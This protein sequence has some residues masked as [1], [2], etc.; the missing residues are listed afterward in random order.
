MVLVQKQAFPVHPSIRPSIHPSFC[1]PS[2]TSLSVH[3]CEQ[4]PQHPQQ[5]CPD[6]GLMQRGQEDASPLR[7]R[8]AAET[9][10][11]GVTHAA[12]QRS[13]KRVLTQRAAR[14]PSALTEAPA[15][16]LFVFETKNLVFLPASP[17]S[18]LVICSVTASVEPYS[19]VLLRARSPLQRHRW[20]AHPRR[21]P[22]GNSSEYF[23]LHHELFNKLKTPCLCDP[24]SNEV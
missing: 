3:H 8:A 1:S 23:Q 16:P 4:H 2:H 12:Q 20:F 11:R 17:F 13:R 7:G 14:S 10:D 21:Q 5:A 22:E 18:V 15:S 19:S 6:V 9:D 24:V